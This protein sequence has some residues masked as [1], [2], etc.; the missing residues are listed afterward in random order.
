M[1]VHDTL[2]NFQLDY[3]YKEFHNIFFDV[4]IISIQSDKGMFGCNFDHTN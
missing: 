1:Y 2:K 3:D 4:N